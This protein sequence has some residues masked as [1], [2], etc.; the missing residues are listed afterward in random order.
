MLK[1]FL[2]LSSSNDASINIVEDESSFEFCPKA[3]FTL[4]LQ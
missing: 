1:V 4:T 3:E 2:L